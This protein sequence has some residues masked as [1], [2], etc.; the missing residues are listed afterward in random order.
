MIQTKPVM[1]RFV[2]HSMMMPIRLAI[3]EPVELP[4]CFD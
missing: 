4:G 3:A 2:R 1:A